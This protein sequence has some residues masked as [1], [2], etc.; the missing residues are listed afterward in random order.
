MAECRRGSEE[1]EASSLSWGTG[2]ERLRRRWILKEKKRFC[3]KAGGR[4]GRLL[5]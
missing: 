3:K 2:G 4:K 1:K 5:K